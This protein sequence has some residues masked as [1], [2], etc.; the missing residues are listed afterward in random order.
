MIVLGVGLAVF[1]SILVI[2]IVF[3]LSIRE[4]FQVWTLSGKI[5]SRR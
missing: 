1:T 2:L 5:T 4:L 3:Q